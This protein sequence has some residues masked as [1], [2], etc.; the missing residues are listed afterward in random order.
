[1][2]EIAVITGRFGVRQL[3]AAFAQASL[4][5]GIGNLM[6]QREQARARGKRQ[7]AAAL[8]SGDKAPLGVAKE[9]R[10]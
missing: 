10:L 5:A 4:L 3:A 6:K 7:Q 2:T 1:M 9:P 8:Q